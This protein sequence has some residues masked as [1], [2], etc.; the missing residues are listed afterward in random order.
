MTDDDQPAARERAFLDYVKHTEPYYEA[1]EAA[2]DRPWFS[3]LEERRELFMRRYT[4]P[5]PPEGLFNDLDTIRGDT[6]DYQQIAQ[7]GS[8][9]ETPHRFIA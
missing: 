9:T 4:R 1:V 3:S 6:C 7:R 5:E 8:S 2:G